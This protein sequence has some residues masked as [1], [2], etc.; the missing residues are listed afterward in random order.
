MRHPYGAN[1]MKIFN[2]KFPDSEFDLFIDVGTS[3]NA[4]TSVDML[5]ALPNAFVI[6]IEPNPTNCESV[7]SLNLGERFHL[8]EAGISDVEEILELKMMHPDPGTSSFL[9]VT[10]VLKDKGYTIVDTVEVP[11]IRLETIL[12]EVPWDKVSKG[13]FTLKS[14]TQGFEDKVVRSLGKYVSQVEHLQIERTTDGQ[15]EE[16]SLHEDVCEFLAP[17]MIET[18][19]DRLDAWFTKKQ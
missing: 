10:N 1:I 17:H 16:S 3:H 19:N 4:P 15:Y 13:L 11:T 14:D 2:I 9:E 18:K 12:D 7:R 5:K 8:V 6:G